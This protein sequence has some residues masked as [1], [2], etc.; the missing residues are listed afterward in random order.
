[1]KALLAEEMKEYEERLQKGE[2]SVNPELDRA[3]MDLK[4]SGEKNVEAAK[5]TAAEKQAEKERKARVNALAGEAR[6]HGAEAMR[7]GAY[8]TGRARRTARAASAR[9]PIDEPVDEHTAAEE[10][11]PGSPPA[12]KG[13]VDIGAA[14]Q[15]SAEADTKL[16]RRE[17]ELREK[18]L[19]LQESQLKLQESRLQLEV[20]ERRATTSVM[21]GLAQVLTRG[22]GVLT[23]AV[24]NATTIEGQASENDS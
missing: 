16:R 14:L 7:T 6:E 2:P 21:A 10:E 3:L 18:E 1:M 4:E 13:K 5:K 24:P 22:A 20:E 11:A 8:P 9:S 23:P 12:K 17:L 15:E 19:K